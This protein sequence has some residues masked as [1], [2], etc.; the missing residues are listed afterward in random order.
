[1]VLELLAM[2]LDDLADV[3]R[4]QKQA[5]E[6]QFVEDMAVYADK[7]RRYPQ[8]C[9]MC[10]ADGIAVGYLVSHPGRLASPPAL[11]TLL[12]NVDLPADGDSYFIHDV[13]VMP[14]H[15]GLGVGGRLVAEALRIAAKH[16]HDVVALVS[17]QGSSS[18]WTR[19]GFQPVSGPPEALNHVRESYG[20]DARYMVR[21][22]A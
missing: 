17:V 6:A 18:Y 4:I 20:D 3:D 14:S 2:K 8:G 11:N 15:R 7:L 21:R 22:T 5:Y 19:Q 13:A 1:M 9:S 16:G 12:A 10:T